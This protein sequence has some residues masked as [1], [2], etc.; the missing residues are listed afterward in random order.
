M[1][2]CHTKANIVGIDIFTGKKYED[3]CQTS[4]NVEVLNIKRAP[5]TEIDFDADRFVSLMDS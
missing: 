5:Y 4:H 3:S 2:T 1:K